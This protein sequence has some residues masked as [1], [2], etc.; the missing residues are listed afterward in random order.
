M[1]I[2]A[3]IVALSSAVSAN[4]ASKNLSKLRAE[5]PDAFR[6]LRL[7]DE[8]WKLLTHYNYR[9]G[10]RR[11]VVEL[12]ER[13]QFGEAFIAHMDAAAAGEAGRADDTAS[14]AAAAAPSEAA[15]SRM[16]HGLKESGAVEVKPIQQNLEPKT[17]IVGFAV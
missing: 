6:S 7:Y 9:L 16:T 12:F 5:A 11:C 1:E 8:A 4:A 2:L 15:S 13:I 10:P 14:A 3:S 17:V